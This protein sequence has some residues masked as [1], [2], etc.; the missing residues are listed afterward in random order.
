[1]A[2]AVIDPATTQKIATEYKVA[3]IGLAAF[4]STLR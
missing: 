3:D 1:M 4:G 2:T